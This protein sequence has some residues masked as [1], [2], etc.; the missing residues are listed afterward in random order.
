MPFLSPKHIKTVN[1]T[2]TT[3]FDI[4][5]GVSAFFPPLTDHDHKYA[6][7][8]VPYPIWIYQNVITQVKK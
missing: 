5:Q 3:E 4:N 6:P 2:P 7:T 1:R 8:S